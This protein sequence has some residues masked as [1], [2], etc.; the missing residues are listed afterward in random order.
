MTNQTAA[1]SEALAYF[2]VALIEQLSSLAL[3]LAGE[4]PDDYYLRNAGAHLNQ[5]I[6]NAGQWLDPKVRPQPDLD[7]AN[8]LIA[9]SARMLVGILRAGI[10]TAK[11]EAQK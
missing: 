9:D 10:K 5:A 1:Q 11:R 2:N 3:E 6:V 4:H 8:N 7:G